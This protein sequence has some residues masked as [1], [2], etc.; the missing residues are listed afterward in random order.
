MV[1]V[2]AWPLSTEV[3]TEG[4]SELAIVA[5]SAIAFS[6]WLLGC[7]F[8]DMRLKPSDDAIDDLFDLFDLFDLLDL[9]D[10]LDLFDLF[11]CCED[12]AEDADEDVLDS[13][14]ASSRIM[15]SPPLFL[16]WSASAALLLPPCRMNDGRLK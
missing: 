16:S 4:S 8:G 3:C 1:P 11:V 5:L 9:L 2:P 7:T 12:E 15:S 13:S 10:L 6:S 14:D